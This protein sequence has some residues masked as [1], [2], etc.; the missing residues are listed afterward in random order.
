MSNKIMIANKRVFLD[1]DGVIADFDNSFKEHI[2]VFP[3]EIVDRN[4]G[5]DGELWEKIK[6]IPEFFKRLPPL[7]SHPH[8]YRNLVSSI[9]LLTGKLPIILTGCPNNIEFNMKSVCGLI[10]I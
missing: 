6:S 8:H 9:E 10:N 3:K 5:D 1:M 7:D 4:N 2:G